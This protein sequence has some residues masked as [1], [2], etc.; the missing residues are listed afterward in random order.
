MRLN[1]SEKR[2]ARKAVIEYVNRKYKVPNMM[3]DNQARHWGLRKLITGYFPSN[4]AMFLAGAYIRKHG[5]LDNYVSNA[6]PTRPSKGFYTSRAWRELRIKALHD[7]GFKC[8]ACGREPR[9]HGVVLHVD[10][11]KPRSKY[12][13][14]ELTFNNLQVLCE[15]CN[16]GKSNHYEEDWRLGTPLRPQRGND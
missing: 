15:D 1:K 6:I 12:P 7:N 9:I 16:L 11:I 13:E 5:N 2:A 8:C 4:Q 10:H 14:L 3:T